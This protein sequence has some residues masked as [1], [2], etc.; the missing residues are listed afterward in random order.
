[1]LVEYDRAL[2]A[3]V[4]IVAENLGRADIA[5]EGDVLLIRHANGTIERREVNEY[6]RYLRVFFP[7][8][9]RQ[10]K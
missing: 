2:A 9:W 1:M 6:G 10:G 3:P 8:P 7:N 4:G 5:A